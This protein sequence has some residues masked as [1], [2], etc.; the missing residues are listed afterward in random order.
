MAHCL[1]LEMLAKTKQ[2]IPQLLTSLYKKFGKFY[3]DRIDL[4]LEDPSLLAQMAE[5]AF[6]EKNLSL[7]SL[8]TLNFDGTKWFFPN[9]RWLLVRRSKTENLLRIY[10]EGTDKKFI[11]AVHSVIRGKTCNNQP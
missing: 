4:K 3:Y 6:W 5:L 1:L 8:R 9:H 11:Q 7:K 2:S 10:F